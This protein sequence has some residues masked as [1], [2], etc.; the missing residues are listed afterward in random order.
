ME[1]WVLIFSRTSS[2]STRFWIPRAKRTCYARY[3]QFWPTSHPFFPFN[4]LHIQRPEIETTRQTLYTYLFL[5]KIEPAA[6][7][8][9]T[10]RSIT[11]FGKHVSLIAA[12]LTQR[13]GRF[14]LMSWRRRVSAGDQRGCRREGNQEQCSMMKAAH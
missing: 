2:R 7:Q 12:L 13:G 3:H 5:L 4:Y 6:I 9:D 11:S 10:S 8:H 1:A 14:Q